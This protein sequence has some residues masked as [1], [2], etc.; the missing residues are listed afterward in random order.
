MLRYALVA[1]ISVGLLSWM[2]VRVLSKAFSACNESSC[3]CGLSVCVHGGLCLLLYICWTFSVF[4][5]WSLQDYG[6]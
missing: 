1:L 3:G 2:G 4:V 5:G 6:T